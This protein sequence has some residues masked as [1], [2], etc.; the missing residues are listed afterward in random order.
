LRAGAV[1]SSGI[2]R[3][4]DFSNSR[5]IFSIRGNRDLF[6]ILSRD[7]S[8]DLSNQSEEIGIYS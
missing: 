2:V 7:F 4:F 6:L 5:I 8:N 1:T 3:D